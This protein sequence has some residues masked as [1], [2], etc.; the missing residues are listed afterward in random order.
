LQW[1]A[2]V[3][4]AKGIWPAE[5]PLKPVEAVERHRAFARMMVG[6]SAEA[7]VPKMAMNDVTSL[8]VWRIATSLPLD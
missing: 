8:K 3:R 5:D 6:Q 1:L 2:V 7:T 4:F